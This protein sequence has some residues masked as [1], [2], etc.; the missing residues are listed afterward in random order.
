MNNF[1]QMRMSMEKKAYVAPTVEV[2]EMEEICIVAGSLEDG[3]DFGGNPDL[4]PTE[5]LSNRRRNYWSE[6]GGSRRWK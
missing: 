2:V 6:V 5:E 3:G 4:P 1:G